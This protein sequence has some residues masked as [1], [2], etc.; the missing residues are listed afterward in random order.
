M[1]A[2]KLDRFTRAED[3]LLGALGYDESASILEVHATDHGYAGSGRYSDGETFDFESTEELQSLEMWALDV[4]ASRTESVAGR[5]ARGI[6]T[7]GAASARN[8]HSR[9]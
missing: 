7:L 8:R 2:E 3:I 1:P 4:M 6:M 5:K 9:K